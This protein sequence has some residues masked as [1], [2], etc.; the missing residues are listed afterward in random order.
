MPYNPY[1]TERDHSL[2]VFRLDSS[3]STLLAGAYLGG[4]GVRS[5]ILD[6][7]GH[8]YIAGVA[9][10]SLFPFTQGAYNKKPFGAFIAKIDGDLSAA[11]QQPLTVVKNS[12][13]GGTVTATGLKCKYGSRCTGQYNVGTEVTITAQAK[14]GFV[15]QEWRGCDSVSGGVCIVTVNMP[16]TV[17]AYFNPPAKIG[18]FPA[19]FAFSPVKTGTV[20]QAK[21]VAIRNS[22]ATLAIS[23]IAITGDG[24]FTQTNN[25]ASLDRCERCWINVTFSPTSP[26]LKTA[27]VTIIS[28]DQ[29][30]GTVTVRLSGIGKGK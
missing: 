11:P 27:Q 6:S 26:G 15:F 30:R 1:P 3:L 14:P 2:F 13:L 18:V 9:T 21:G 5:L 20:S 17:F 29:R 25:C 7:G 8:V 16:R 10:S 23:S 4:E 19:S 22:G 24:S 12:N 28:N